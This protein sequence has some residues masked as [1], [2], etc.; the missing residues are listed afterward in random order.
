MTWVLIHSNK[1]LI[2]I[3]HIL[4]SLLLYDAR[5]VS[6]FLILFGT[7]FLLS[8]ANSQFSDFILL[9]PS[10]TFDHSFIHSFI[11]S[12]FPSWIPGYHFVL[13]FLLFLFPHGVP[14]CTWF[15]LL[16]FC[17]S[18]FKYYSNQNTIFGLYLFLA[19]SYFISF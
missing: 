19:A 3:P 18:A 2:P 10:S 17:L 5:S 16:D 14:S 12:Y 8:K 15:S 6:A 9:R 1:S 4:Y 7:L 13:G 11:H